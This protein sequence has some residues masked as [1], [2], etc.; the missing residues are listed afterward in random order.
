M[1]Q[2]SLTYFMKL[3]SAI[4]RKSEQSE[5][6]NERIEILIREITKDIY[7]NICRGL[8]NM[9]KLIFAF[10]IAS[11][12]FLKQGK[13][14]TPEWDI[15][16]KGVIM[17]GNIKNLKNPN[18]TLITEKQWKFMLNLECTH[19]SFE[20]LPDDL[21]KNF[22]GWKKWMEDKEP[23]NKNLPGNWSNKLSFF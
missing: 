14:T 7:N 8:F 13:I 15:Y 17:D 1:Y 11:R 22:E 20:G 19:P 21:V 12:I 3:F 18:T 5:D 6:I 9:H 2:Y 16:L 10:L 4:I 23:Q